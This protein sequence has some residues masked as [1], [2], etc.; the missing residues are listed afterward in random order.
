M[1]EG[2]L[3]ISEKERLGRMLEK[4]GV[5]SHINN[6]IIFTSYILI[7]SVIIPSN[8]IFLIF[9]TNFIIL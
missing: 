8:L 4:V 2:E 1:V 6:F 5:R 3:V 9:L 7:S